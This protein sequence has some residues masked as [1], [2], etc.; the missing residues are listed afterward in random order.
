MTTL[1]IRVSSMREAIRLVRR[2][3]RISKELG[4]PFD[5]VFQMEMS[6]LEAEIR[7]SERAK[8]RQA[9]QRT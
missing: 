7:E 2:C 8:R 3:R 6:V 4:I 5:D 1:R 9:N